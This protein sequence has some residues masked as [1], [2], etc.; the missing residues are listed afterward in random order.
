MDPFTVIVML[1]IHLVASGGL[2]FLVWRLMPDAP[3][4]A[5]WALASILFGL[6]YLSRLFTGVQTVD[7]I[8]MAFDGVM[9]L[10]VMLFSEGLREFAG[11]ALAPWRQRMMP[12]LLIYA[13]QVSASLIGGVL[14]RHI[15]INLATGA[16]YVVMTWSLAF[17]IRRQPVALHAP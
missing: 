3:G 6:A 7:A 13:A 14:W 15:G 1:A 11:V 5:R 9:L 12:W 16:M 17:E 10:A 4:L 8:S 2:M